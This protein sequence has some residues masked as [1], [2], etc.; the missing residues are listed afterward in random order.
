MTAILSSLTMPSVTGEVFTKRVV[1][2]YMLHEV[3]YFAHSQSFL[4]KRIL[5]PSCGKGAFVLPLVETVIADVK[6]WNDIRLDALL[7]ACD[8]S[9]ANVEYTRTLLIKMLTGSGCPAER[10]SSLAQQWLVCDDFL[11]HEFHW[12]FDVI[13]GNPPYIRFDDIS[14]ER[15]KKYKSLFLTF[16]ERCDIY[17]AFLEKSLGM[18]SE[19]GILSFICSNRFTKSSY[20]KRIREYISRNFHVTLYLNMEHSA[21]F[22]EEVAAYPGI[23]VIDRLKEAKT[24]SKTIDDISEDS[25]VACHAD[26]GTLDEFSHWYQGDAPWITTDS[27][28]LAFAKQIT[29]TF[30][31][32]EQS[33]KN[34]KI[35]IGVASGADDIFIVPDVC[36]IEKACL[37]PLVMAEDIKNG[38]LEWKQHYILNPFDED[39]DRRLK[40]LTKYPQTNAYLQ[41][42][43]TRLKSRYCVKQ[44]PN[45]WYRT[46]DRINYDLL[47]KPKILMPDIQNG[48]NVALDEAGCFYPHHNVYWM[49]SAEWNLRALCV[50]MRSSFVTDQIRIFSVEMRGGFIRYQAQNLRKIHIPSCQS[51]S[52]ADIELLS[53]LYYEKDNDVI[54]SAVNGIVQ[55]VASK[56]RQPMT[57]MELFTDFAI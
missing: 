19:N 20:G 28:H 49:T 11:L 57:Q 22:E 8:I 34:T 33:G 37:L 53:A 45:V 3:A 25:L 26:K 42:N 38:T 41:K 31:S 16:H 32:L 55:N 36:E 6:D 44:R 17:V 35:G 9:E 24:L 10:A 13:I 4:G 12:T 5:E 48:R 30:V 54:D 46:L 50:M 52:S 21:P 40:D 18:L 14:V 23:F 43:A 7:I 39:D 47:K 2:D 1:V 15:L 56:Q 27:E 29:N 51:L